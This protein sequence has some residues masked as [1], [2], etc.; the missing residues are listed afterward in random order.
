MTRSL[1]VGVPSLA[2]ACGVVATVEQTVVAQNQVPQ[3]DLT[4]IELKGKFEEWK[5]NLLQVTDGSG[6]KEK[7]TD[8][9]RGAA[10]FLSRHREVGLDTNRNVCQA[11]G[12][13]GRSDAASH[14]SI[15][16]RVVSADAKHATRQ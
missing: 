2:L 7:H 9:E 11:D 16:S 6:K 10:G 1:R 8:A 14:A 5:S 15:R 4:V 12:R 13:T 3:N